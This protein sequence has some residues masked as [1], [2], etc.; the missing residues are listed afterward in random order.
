MMKVY[1]DFSTCV[2]V[3]IFSAAQCA[4]ISQLVS[5][6]L[7]QVIDPCVA[8]YSVCSWVEGKSRAFYSAILLRIE[9]SLF[10]FKNI[11]WFWCSS[12]S[13]QYV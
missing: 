10:S 12:A 4:G 11:L 3:G 6:F 7:S 13:L 5:A 8:V 9:L 1:L 2:D